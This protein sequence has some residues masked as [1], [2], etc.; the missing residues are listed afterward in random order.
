MAV[1][2]PWSPS[3]KEPWDRHRAA[4]FLRR[5]GAMPRL[6]DIEQA[7]SDGYPATV[8]KAFARYWPDTSFVDSWTGTHPRTSPPPEGIQYDTWFE[9]HLWRRRRTT[10]WWMRGLFRQ[11]SSLEMTMLYFWHTTFVTSYLGG[12]FAE[13][14]W[15]QI[16]LF[17][18]NL[19]GDLREVAKK[20]T[21]DVSMLIYLS[22]F[23]NFVHE[24]NRSINENYARELLE[25]FLMGITDLDGNKNYTEEDIREL[26]RCFTGYY[27]PDSDRGDIYKPLHSAWGEWLWDD[28]PKTIFGRTGNYRTDDAIDVLFEAKGAEIAEY[29]AKRLYQTFIADVPDKEFVRAVAQVLQERWSIEDAVRAII[30]STHFFE[31]KNAGLL[32]KNHMSYLVNILRLVDA[33]AIPDFKE[34]RGSLLLWFWLTE[35]H[36]LGHL[37]YFPS[38]VSGWT[39]GR[40]WVSST[41]VQRRL[42]FA[43]RVFEG[44]LTTSYSKPDDGTPACTFSAE[45]L[46]A[47]YSGGDKN[48]YIFVENIL[49]VFFGAPALPREVEELAEILL[50]GGP[51]YEWD[52]SLPAN[53]TDERVRRMLSA[54]ATYPKFQLY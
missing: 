39:G 31:S 33:S 14:V 54:M 5:I 27:H 3:E 49:L 22:G 32:K 40:D 42:D 35:E 52:P 44:R 4:H 53:R 9:N 46:V 6:R 19:Y 47:E 51:A 25:I 10:Q 43:Q 37:P 50:D 38:N 34:G 41:A 36:G 24:E 45:A 13:Y 20:V 12:P 7:L 16:E 11:P 23:T 48:P 18:D 15:E 2:L 21:K 8:E 28:Q 29:T 30:T 1:L 26:A 17:R